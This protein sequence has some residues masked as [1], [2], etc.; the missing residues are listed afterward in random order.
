MNVVTLV[1]RFL[2]SSV[3]CWTANF[4]NHTSKGQVIIM[5]WLKSIYSS[6]FTDLHSH[7]IHT[8]FAIIASNVNEHSFHFV[9][10]SLV[11]VLSTYT[12]KVTTIA[13]KE[14]STITYLLRIFLQKNSIIAFAVDLFCLSIC[15]QQ[16]CCKVQWGEIHKDTHDFSLYLTS[17]FNGF[18][19]NYIKFA[20]LIPH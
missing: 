13:K 16:I 18:L 12:T 4:C 17:F 20:S 11:L 5:N 19:W 1:N 3:N 2:T 6:P 8:C 14:A 15:F 7:P 10:L 9:T